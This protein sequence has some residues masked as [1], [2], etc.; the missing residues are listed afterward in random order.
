[1]TVLEVDHV[2]L[3]GRPSTPAIHGTDPYVVVGIG[4]ALMAVPRFVRV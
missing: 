2:I 1:M 3:T 4:V